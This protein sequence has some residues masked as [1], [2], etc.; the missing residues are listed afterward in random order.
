MTEVTR[1]VSAVCGML[2]VVEAA[3]RLVPRHRMVGFVKA[4]GGLFLLA[5]VAA[6][7]FRLDWEPLSPARWEGSADELIAALEARGEEA[8]ALEGERYVA[9]LL[10]SADIP[11]KKI[12]V[13]AT[14]RA[15]GRIH[16]TSVWASFRYG[17]DAR[18]A[19]A[20]LTGVLEA[21]TTVEVASDDS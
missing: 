18:R 13:K 4:L 16:Y 9:G 3:G 5:S 6:S 2:L 11:V 8:A 21:D 20:L 15:D 12:S 7:L 10:A 17:S 19:R 14:I 1:Q